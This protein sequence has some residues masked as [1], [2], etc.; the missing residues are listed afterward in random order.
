MSPQKKGDA[1]DW[2][3]VLREAAPYLSLG[4]SLAVTVLLGVGLGY[5]ADRRL[6]TRPWL[7]LLGA[8][9]GLVLA[10]YQFFK[11]VSRR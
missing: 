2:V 4:T 6:G 10:L 11:T 1:S 7:F 9:A 5:W 3:R 8:A